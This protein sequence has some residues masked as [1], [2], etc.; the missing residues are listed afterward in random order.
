VNT[1]RPVVLAIAADALICGLLED[2]FSTFRAYQVELIDEPQAGLARAEAGRMDLI[3]LD[4]GWPE[5]SGI[6][7]CGQLRTLPHLAAIPII[8]LTDLP[9][10]QC[11]VTGFVYGPNEYIKKPFHIAEL[12]AAIERYCPV[13]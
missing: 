8:A 1:D 13:S 3:I 12:L 9:A 7:F 5:S 10:E 2:V 4:L 6:E 11:I